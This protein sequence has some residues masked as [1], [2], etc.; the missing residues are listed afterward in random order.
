MTTTTQSQSA[1]KM[2]PEMIKHLDDMTI[3]YYT[4]PSP[5]YEYGENV[6]VAAI[7]TAQSNDDDYVRVYF[8]DVSE[9]GEPLDLRIVKHDSNAKIVICAAISSRHIL[10][11]ANHK[12]LSSDL[13]KKETMRMKH[14]VMRSFFY[15][16]EYKI[17]EKEL[18]Y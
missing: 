13:I 1:N 18:I 14:L 2:H 17:S 10:A 3:I 6:Q 7:N 9:Q 16:H 12:T 5:V 8:A 4:R 15:K 11:C